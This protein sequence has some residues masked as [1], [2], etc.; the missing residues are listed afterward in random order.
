MERCREPVRAAANF[1]RYERNRG[2]SGGL[3]AGETRGEENHAD[4]LLNVD[5]LT[6]RLERTVP[7]IMQQRAGQRVPP[8]PVD[9]P[10]HNYNLSDALI[11]ALGDLSYPPAVDELFK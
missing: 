2:R 1:E 4:E 10:M 7:R 6:L 9:F 3:F 11:E 8:M 5:N